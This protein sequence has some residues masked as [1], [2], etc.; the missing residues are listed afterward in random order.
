M[1]RLLMLQLLAHTTVAVTES[2]G[3]ITSAAPSAPA[4]LQRPPAPRPPQQLP[5]SAPVASLAASRAHPQAVPGAPGSIPGSP[6]PS[7]FS[8]SV[9]FMPKSPAMPAPFR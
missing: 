5:R 2:R 9:T 8:R 6:A 3:P 1:L 7:I 4:L